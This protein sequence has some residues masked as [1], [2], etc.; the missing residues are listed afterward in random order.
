MPSTLACA[1]SIA[2]ELLRRVQELDRSQERV[3]T[4]VEAINSFK[5]YW[6]GAIALVNQTVAL[7]SQHG[8]GMA[9][10]DDDALLVTKNETLTSFGAAFAAKQET[11]KSQATSLATMQ[12]QLAI[13]SNYAWL[14]ASSPRNIYTPAQHQ[15]T[16]K[17]GR[18]RCNGGGPAE[19]TNNHLVWFRQGEH[20]AF[21]M[22]SHSLQALGELELLPHTWR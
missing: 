7:A 16:S 13:S 15:R 21:P 14:S 17:N 1:S 22:C 3:P 20:N 9:E 6:S 5:E 11:I 12:C 19:A 8:Y 4:I 18:G 2:A 10:V